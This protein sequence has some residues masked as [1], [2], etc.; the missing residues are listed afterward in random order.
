MGAR[1]SASHARKR[2]DAALALVATG[3]AAAVLAGCGGEREQPVAAPETPA[4]EP[5]VSAKRAAAETA[6][7]APKRRSLVCNLP[8]GTGKLPASRRR[9]LIDHL[10][11]YPDV[12]VATPAE[13]RRAERMLAQ[14]VSA[15][16]DGRWR[17][18]ASA[19]RAGYGTRTAPRQAGDDST[20]YLHSER[21]E[22]PRRRVL[23]DPRRPKALIYA[24]APGRPL[25]LVGAMWSMR[26]DE[27][28][29][30]P[31]GPITRWHTHVVCAA[32]GRRGLTPPPGGTCPAGTRLIQGHSEMLHVWFTRDLRSAFAIRAPEPE[33]CA[34]GLLPRGHCERIA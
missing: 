30:N 31:G 11:Q 6:I 1:P 32:P 7:S 10:L 5:V 16:K 21:R 27:R 12:S 29:P 14:L 17:N 34:A 22:E 24:N 13:R 18:L 20:H 26:P 33:L 23:L 28:G 15:A 4:A 9:G 3:I 25:V 2:R 8:R 19:S